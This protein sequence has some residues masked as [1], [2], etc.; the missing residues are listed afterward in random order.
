MIG[1]LTQIN[2]SGSKFVVVNTFKES[3]FY[4]FHVLF[5]LFFVLFV[6][7][8]VFIL[9]RAKLFI[10]IDDIKLQGY[11]RGRQKAALGGNIAGPLKI[12]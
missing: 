11:N 4:V 3:F 10:F 8:S 2:I 9:L 5:L 6:N 7:S 1:S 12:L